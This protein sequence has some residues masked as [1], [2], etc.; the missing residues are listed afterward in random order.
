MLEAI[1]L[2]SIR[3]KG[4]C[5]SLF[6]YPIVKRKTVSAPDPHNLFPKWF[7]ISRNIIQTSKV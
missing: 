5:A 2:R 7:A 4:R 3:V 6:L 1:Q